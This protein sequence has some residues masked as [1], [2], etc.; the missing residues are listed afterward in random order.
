MVTPH[1]THWGFR[2]DPRPPRCRAGSD[3]HPS[4]SVDADPGELGPQVVD[5]VRQYRPGQLIEVV[6]DRPRLVHRRRLAGAQ[7]VGEPEQLD[8][9]GQP[10]VD[11]GAGSRS[12]TSA[13]PPAQQVGDPAQDRQHALPGGFG[14]V[15]GEDGPQ[16]GVGEQL[17]Q[18][19]SRSAAGLALCSTR[20]T[21]RRSGPPSLRRRVGQ[22]VRAVQ[23]LGHVG[24]L[25]ERGERAGQ[26]HRRRHVD[27]VQRAVLRVRHPQAGRRPPGRRAGVPARPAPAAPAPSWRTR[28]S[29]SI[30]PSRRMS[31][32]SAL[33]PASDT[34]P[35]WVSRGSRAGMRL[36]P[37]RGSVT[38]TAN[39]LSR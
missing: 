9:F 8:Q 2:R 3:G 25:E 31:A 24:Q 37:A 21:S 16:L 5:Q 38:P 29:P 28:V 30:S 10:V 1:L 18:V 12:A 19:R 27:P 36:S 7:L 14:R 33:C 6:R 34:T 17:R 13:A 4:G 26:Q 22:L 11:H 39:R 15:S 23:L 32:R 35:A 20:S